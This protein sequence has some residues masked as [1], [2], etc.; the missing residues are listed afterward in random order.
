MSNYSFIF[1]EK[2]FFSDLKNKKLAVIIGCNDTYA[3]YA[4]QAILKFQ[5]VNRKYDGFILGTSFSEESKKSIT[6]AGLKCLELNLENYFPFLD[7][8]PRGEKYPI[9]CFY[10]LY[11]YKVLPQYDYI[12]SI[13]PDIITQLPF[14]YKDFPY[15]AGVVDGNKIKNFTPI[16]KDLP[17]I[18]TAYPNASIIGDRIMGGVKIYN[19]KGCE[20]IHFFETIA[21]LYKKSWEINAPQC[22]DDSLF[23]MYQMIYPET[24][25]KLNKKFQV[26]KN[27]GVYHKNIISYHQALTSKWWDD[28]SSV[29]KTALF[30]KNQMRSFVGLDECKE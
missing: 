10:H 26:I 28:S 13:E 1:H 6:D 12:I 29:N 15:V 17:S 21:E 7:K 3:E 5:S 16:M 30:F 20:S 23:I 27:T 8:R 9:E 4:K 25:S 18:L 19:V 2:E 24:V 22:G 14:S 11:A